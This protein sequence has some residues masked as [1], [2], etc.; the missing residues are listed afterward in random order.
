MKTKAVCLYGKNDI[1]DREI[2]LPPI[3]ADEILLKVLA[4][5]LCLSTYK[6]LQAGTEHKRVP[7]DVANH[8]AITGH[9]FVGSIVEIGSNWQYKYKK[10]DIVVLQPA[11][12]QTGNP[13]TAGYSYE[14]FGGNTEYTIIPKVALELNCLIPYSHSFLANGA[15]AEPMSCIIG[16]FH[17]SYHDVPYEYNH[18]MG[19]RRGGHMALLASCGPMGLGAIDYALNGPFAPSVLLVVDIDPIR[20]ARA[21]QIFARNALEVGI[22]LT[23]M[24]IQGLSDPLKQIR[25]LNGD[26]GFDDVFVFSAI[27]ELLDMAGDMLAYNGCLNFFAGPT[28]KDFKAPF[29]FYDLHYNNTHVVGTSGGSVSDMIESLQLSENGKIN[30][31]YMITH[32]GGLNCVAETKRALPQIHGGKKFTYSHINMELTAIEDFQ[33][34]GYK[35]PFFKGLYDI[36]A[37]HNMIWNEEA[38]RFL[39]QHKMKGE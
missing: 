38:E 19:P 3:T 39:L 33:K 13:H 5:G 35:D 6:A 9:E 16:A 31:A 15:L 36:V 20:I 37:K 25:A 26:R 7:Q 32:I 34:L 23:F 29:N 8:P 28:K 27:P 24:N 11:M 2:E 21:Q 18:Q 30:P 22:D 17:A 10:G 12:S 4:N 14:Y 1:R